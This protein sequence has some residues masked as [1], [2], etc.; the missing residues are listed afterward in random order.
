MGGVMTDM[1]PHTRS[2]YIIVNQIMIKKK[3]RMKNFLVR[4]ERTATHTYI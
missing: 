4:F 3:T 1:I 2:G